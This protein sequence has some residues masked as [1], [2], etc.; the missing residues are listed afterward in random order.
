MSLQKFSPTKLLIASA[1]SSLAISSVF[2]PLAEAQS[3]KVRYVPPSN[4][5]TPIVSTPGIIRSSGCNEQI[6][7][8]GLVP[9][10]AAE[11]SPVPQTISDSPTF[12]FLVP[13]IDG[14][15][16]FYLS[17][18]DSSLT[19][20]KRVYRTS[21]KIKNK[22]GILAFKM[23]AVKGDSILELNKNYVWEFTVGSFTDAETVRGSIRRV[24]PSPNLANQLKKVSLPLDRAALFAQEGI[25]FETVQTLADA[26]QAIYKKPE[27]VNEW[28]EL[29]KSAKLDRVLKHTFLKSAVINSGSV[30]PSNQN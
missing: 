29:L 13:E 1:F 11:N 28:K 23:P 2:T 4:L 8:I 21:F 15:A 3:R 9:D 26:Q 6:C 16:Y 14:R 5:G 30:S 25:W 17:E 7:L 22:A 18:A 20:G 12:Y 19:K 10:F 24:L 27:I